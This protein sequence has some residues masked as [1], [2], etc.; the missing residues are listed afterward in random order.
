MISLPGKIRNRSA[1]RKTS[2]IARI[3]KPG[4]IKS[5][6]GCKS[7]ISIR[8]PKRKA[9]NDVHASEVRSSVKA[10]LEW[11]RL[12]G[13]RL[14]LPYGGAYRAFGGTGYIINNHCHRCG[15]CGVSCGVARSR[16]QDMRTIR[17][18]GGIPRPGIR[19]GTKFLTD[20]LPIHSQLNSDY[21]N[22]VPGIGRNVDGP[23][24]RCGLLWIGYLD[25]GI[26]LIGATKR[27]D[28]EAANPMGRFIC[29][30]G[31]V[32]QLR[33]RALVTPKAKVAT[34]NG[35]CRARHCYINRVQMAGRVDQQ[36]IVIS[37]PRRI[38]NDGVG[39][40]IIA[41]DSIHEPGDIEAH[42]GSQ[43]LITQGVIQRQSRHAI[44]ILSVRGH[45]KLC[46]EGSNLIREWIVLPCAGTYITLDRCR[47]LKVALHTSFGEAGIY[48][49]KCEA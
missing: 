3:D 46:Y 4:G 14:V 35:L 1:G 31:P 30:K 42:N 44:H 25:R 33:S 29:E 47:P 21:T 37:Y 13:N 18:R 12:R 16:G 28:A 27:N 45:I 39:A 34:E 17:N 32:V 24:Y 40:I 19:H 26:R 7:R 2:T 43:I 15:C 49:T 36:S 23:E 38:G 41:V 22:V 20:W 10:G 48:D 9:S 6:A 11:C 8:S 5:H